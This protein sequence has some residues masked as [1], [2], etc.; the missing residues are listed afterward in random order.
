VTVLAS[1]S[2]PTNGHL[3]ADVAKLGY[4]KSDDL[5]LDLTYGEG[6]W[7]KQWRPSVL[8][9]LHRHGADFRDTKFRDGLF[10]VVA[11]DPP[12]KLNGRPDPMIDERYG[13][14]ERA[15]TAERLELIQGGIYEAARV[16]QPG[17]IVLVKCQDQVVSGAIVWQTHIVYQAAWMVGLEQVDRFDMTGHHRKQ[18][19]EGRRQQHAHGRPS[20]L[21]VFRKKR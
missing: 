11:F 8:T 1:H 21:L 14:H 2:W 5:V 16:V 17:G 3:I 7:W 20:T 4:I 19:M 10:D 6:V 13:V 12:Y 18:P 15:T 9:H